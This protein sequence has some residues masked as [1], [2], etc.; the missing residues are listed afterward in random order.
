MVLIIGAKTTLAETKRSSISK[1]TTKT[2]KSIQASRKIV[3]GDRVIKDEM[4]NSD[5]KLTDLLVDELDSNGYEYE[6]STV[7]KN[8]KIE[9]CVE[10]K[11]LVKQVACINLEKLENNE[12]DNI[13]SYVEDLF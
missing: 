7:F 9:N 6:L 8:V 5:F 12:K 13:A 10:S 1:I 2:C 3:C 11:K 4:K